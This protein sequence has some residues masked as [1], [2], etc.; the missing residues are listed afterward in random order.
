MSRLATLEIGELLPIIK[1]A[2]PL[3]WMASFLPVSRDAG[4]IYR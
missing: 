3:G 4:H 1:E 2:I